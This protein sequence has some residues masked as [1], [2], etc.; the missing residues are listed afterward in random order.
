[1]LWEAAL[2]R[3][4]V[5]GS[6]TATWQISTPAYRRLFEREAGILFTEDDL[7]WY[8][9]RPTPQSGL[10]FSYGDRI[11]RFAERSGML[12]FG[13]HL[14]WDD[15]FGNGWKDGDIEGLGSQRARDMLF[16]T[17]DSVVRH[18]R[19]RIAAWSVANEVFDVGGLR[20]DVPW[21]TTIGPSYVAEAFRIAHRADPKA[22]LALNDFGFETDDGFTTAAD[23]RAAALRM[24]DDL[25]TE[26]A[27]VHALGIQA[28]LKA[29]D[30]DT[31]FDGQ[32]YRAWLRQV[33]AR[34]VKILITELDVL[35]D[36]LPAA[37]GPRDRG[38]ADVTKAYLDVALAEPAVTTL[39]TFG[40]SDRFTWLQEDY[41]RDDGA[42]RRPLPFDEDLR[43]KPAYDALSHSL[44][45]A[46]WRHP[47]W[48]VRRH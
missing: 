47:L 17:V 22:V 1:V 24:V 34:G 44:R 4:L 14:V 23:K 29:Q 15:G 16:S 10:D 28:H 6:S 27:P 32:A 20:T 19:R 36:G 40:L 2:K 38:V 37:T 13:A 43:P 48:P 7:L 35:D 21:Y 42:A 3:G 45:R 33:A 8:R 39:M 18:Y 5:Y 12:V 31:G 9:L 26:N 46:P 11:V 30:F 41:P 25:R